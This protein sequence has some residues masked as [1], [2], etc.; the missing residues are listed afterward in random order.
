M[1]YESSKDY[2]TGVISMHFDGDSPSLPEID[3]YL[4]ANYGTGIC[5]DVEIEMPSTFRGFK[6]PG[7]VTVRT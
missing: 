3:D 5:G 1:I 6:N 2:G 7:I 4:V